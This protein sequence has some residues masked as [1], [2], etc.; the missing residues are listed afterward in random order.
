VAGQGLCLTGANYSTQLKWH[1]NVPLL[2]VDCAGRPCPLCGGPVDVF[3]DHAVACKKS[4]FGDRHLGTQT[5]FWQVL[6]QSRV[7]HD[8]LS[9]YL[10]PAPQGFFKTMFPGP[11]PP[12]LQDPESG[13]PMD[14]DTLVEGTGVIDMVNDLAAS[15]LPG[16]GIQILNGSSDLAH[17]FLLGTPTSYITGLAGLSPGP[18]AG[19]P[20]G[21]GPAAVEAPTDSYIPALAAVSPVPCPPLIYSPT[22]GP[23]HSSLGN[24]STLPEP[25]TGCFPRWTL[26][27]GP[28]WAQ[29]RGH[30]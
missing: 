25:T 9:V 2:P 12:G 20:G 28:R 24:S 18:I 3:G 23:P 11:G 5:F 15:G 16:P 30:R 29:P 22:G 8:L 17:L 21:G 13:R 4:G 26:S 27:C 7:P 14:L 6:T 10:F 1:L 19:P